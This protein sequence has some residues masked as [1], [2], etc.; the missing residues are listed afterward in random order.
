MA[1][2]LRGLGLSIQKRGLALLAGAFGLLAAAADQFY[3]TH[4][5]AV[6][7]M[8]GDGEVVH[9]TDRD[10]LAHSPLALLESVS[11]SRHL[12]RMTIFFV[13]TLQ[14]RARVRLGSNKIVKSHRR[15]IFL[16][17]DSENIFSFF[18]FFQPSLTLERT[19]L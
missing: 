5:S 11:L 2:V 12:V 1:R 18:Q 4:G 3:V 13:S 15:S 17:I 10:F 9:R 8:S 16:T 7:Q 14:S 6:A 19:A